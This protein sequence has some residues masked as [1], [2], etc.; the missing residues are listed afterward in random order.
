M[1]YSYNIE[2]LCIRYVIIYYKVLILNMKYWNSDYY[3]FNIIIGYYRF[4]FFYMEFLVINNMKGLWILYFIYLYF[5]YK[6]CGVI[7]I[8]NKIGFFKFLY[9]DKDLKILCIG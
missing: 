1:R 4:F 8:E 6:Y 7:Y 3:M 5:Y 2:I 9:F